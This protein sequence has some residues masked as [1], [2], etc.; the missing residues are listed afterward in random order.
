MQL[1]AW[2]GA[3]S[4]ASIIATWTLVTHLQA[5]ELDAYRKAD[6]WKASETISELRKLS[7]ELNITLAER[8][9]L[10]VLRAN[11]QAT[12]AIQEQLVT[13][14]R[15]RDRLAATVNAMTVPAMS[16]AV[17]EG[18]S[19]YIIPNVLL[20]GVVSA[21]TGINR[22]EIRIGNRGETLEI[23]GEI[24]GTASGINYQLRLTS[25][26]DNSCGFSFVKVSKPV[27]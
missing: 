7:S 1:I 19:K 27:V 11:Q 15:E 12:K 10:T 8:K 13:V 6:Q 20:V 23:G 16:F 17:N 24:G 26:S 14:T 5:N 2:L 18:D 3:V 9:E 22:C 4:S 25:V 21:Y